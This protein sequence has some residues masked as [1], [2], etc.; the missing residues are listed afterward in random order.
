M[1]RDGV[2]PHGEGLRRAVRWMAQQP[3]HDRAVLNEAGQR[4]D[5]TPLEQEFLAHY[6][7]PWESKP[8]GKE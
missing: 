6:F 8:E 7:G 3:R 1:A 5:L 4:F 2:V